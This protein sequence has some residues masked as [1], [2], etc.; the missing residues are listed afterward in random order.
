MN[1]FQ[2]NACFGAFFHTEA[3]CQVTLCEA[4]TN[5]QNFTQKLRRPAAHVNPHLGS[6][7]C[8]TVINSSLDIGGMESKLGEE[9]S[10]AQTLYVGAL[11]L[12]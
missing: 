12:G 4:F 11:L 2:V 8:G 3:A 1:V 9:R 6:N 7:W 10:N 5:S